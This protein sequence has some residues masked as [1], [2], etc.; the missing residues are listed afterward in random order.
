[1]L[2]LIIPLI[3]YLVVTN[4]ITY[5]AFAND[6][7]YAIEKQQRTPEATLLFWAAI[8]GWFGAKIAQKRLRHKSSKQPFGSRLNDIGLLYTLSFGTFMV[9]TTALF[10]LRRL[11]RST[12][13]QFRRAS[14]KPL[15]TIA[16][17]SKRR[18][19]HQQHAL[20]RAKHL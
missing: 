3:L 13:H 9:I 15:Q 4:L 1:M 12:S 17:R 11:T 7:R 19:A 6:K 18:F 2:I 14:Y 8:G 16:L 10:F 20:H 5:R